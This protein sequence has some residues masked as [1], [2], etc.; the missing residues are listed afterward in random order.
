MSVNENDSTH[1][2]RSVTDD[3]ETSMKLNI[4]SALQVYRED[5]T[6]NPRA[7][8]EEKLCEYTWVRHVQDM[9]EWTRFQNSTVITDL[10]HL[11]KLLCLYGLLQR[12]GSSGR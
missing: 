4:D 8:H 6:Q 11:L 1:G 3:I 12:I 10:P 2:V 9:T 5:V 7:T